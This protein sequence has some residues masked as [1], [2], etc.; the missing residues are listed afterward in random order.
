MKMQK[1]ERI[2]GKGRNAVRMAAVLGAALILAWCEPMVGRAEPTGTVKPRS[3]NIRKEPNQDS[4]V[5]GST[6]G[7]KEISI[8]GKVDVS[9]VTWYQVYVQGD[10]LGYVRADMVEQKGDENI[11]TVSAPSADSGQETPSEEAGEQDT[12]QAG[13]SESSASGGAQV[14]VQE[15]MEKQ[16][17]SIKVASA[18]VRPDPSTSNNPVESIPSGTQVVVSGKS[19]GTDSKTWY[20]VTFTGA[21]GSEKTGY[22]R[23]DLLELGEMLPVEEPPVEE[24]PV[25]EPEEPEEPAPSDDYMVGTET[26]SEGEQVWYIYDNVTGQKQKLVPLLEAS[27][28]NALGNNEDTGAIVKQRI[29]IVAL[30]V[31]L[32]VAV[33][34]I[35]VMA[36]KLRDAYYEDFEDDEEDEEE[37]EEP[38]DRRSARRERE[39][40]GE[41]RQPRRKSADE[42][43]RGPRKRAED[44]EERRPRKRVDDEE[45]RRPRKRGED[46]E[47]RRPRRRED[48]EPASRAKSDRTDRRHREISYEEP[49]AKET[50][51]PAKG[52]K[53]KNFL[54][55]DDEFEF[56]FLNMDDKDLK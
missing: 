31:L 40:N 52:R 53:A 43:E 29:V 34:A 32:A 15:E 44:E 27:Y 11:P 19:E 22:I 38:A 26:D 25:E 3:V 13:E 54:L 48:A 28:A 39:N 37:D 50:A 20:Y 8:K 23:S 5:I 16:Y 47:E 7:G 18:K 21:N 14:Q 49:D 4:E 42:E 2:R 17:A 10:T 51:R 6:T 9:G 45:E 36:F 46:E 55:D 33:I 41:E 30:A 12:A 24:T 1:S 35:I 56:E